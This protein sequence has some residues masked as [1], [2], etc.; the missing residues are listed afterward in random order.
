MKP[1]KQVFRKKN[2]ISIF[3]ELPLILNVDH[4]TKK[5]GEKISKGTPNIEFEQDWS[6]GLGAK[7]RDKQKI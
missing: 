7:L 3:C 4:K 5:K 6:V 1:L 2:L